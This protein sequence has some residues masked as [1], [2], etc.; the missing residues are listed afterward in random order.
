MKTAPSNLYDGLCSE[1]FLWAAYLDYRSGKRRRPAVAAFD[2]DADVAVR[3]LSRDLTNERYFPEPFSMRVIR[4]P[5]VRL[6]CA[7]S[8][9][10]RIL[11]HALV[12][13]ISP[14]F[15]PSFI[16]DSF[17]WG[18]RR[19]PH[20]AVLRAV[21]FSRRARFKRILDVR[22]YFLSVHHESLAQCL[23]ARLRDI[24]LQTLIWKLLR[25]GGSVFRH[26]LAI[27]ALGLDA[28]PVPDGCG[29]A[30]GTHFSQWCGSLY[31]NGLDHFVK[32]TLKVKGYIRYMDDLLFFGDSET[33]LAEVGQAVADW[34]KTHRRLELKPDRVGIVP[35]G[36]ASTYLGYRISRSGIRPGPKLKKNMRIRLRIA[37]KKGHQV[38]RRVEASYHG[39]W[40]L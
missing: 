10:D 25:A 22:R 7:P 40:M 28:D 33:E 15:A 13:L 12:G 11:H 30:V 34:L 26:P 29:L 20:R 21:H 37:A 39:L 14:V 3:R 35:T 23:F 32:R 4:E 2:L 8:L 31:L 17:A 1:E 19:G 9:P 16:Y 38:L 36:T 5:K 24:R 27:E 18:L 6:I